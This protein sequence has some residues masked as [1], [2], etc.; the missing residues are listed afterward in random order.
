[1]FRREAMDK[2][3][4]LCLVLLTGLS[5]VPLFTAGEQGKRDPASKTK[6]LIKVQMSTEFLGREFVNRPK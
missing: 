5:V 2:S 6:G 3:F 4:L 1:M